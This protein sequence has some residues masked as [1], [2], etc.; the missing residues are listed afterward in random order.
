[1]KESSIVI[2]SYHSVRVPFPS[3]HSL[4]TVQTSLDLSRIGEVYFYANRGDDSADF[5]TLYGADLTDVSS[6]H[7]RITRLKHKGLAGIEK[8]I[9]VL[10]DIC[11]VGDRKKIVYVTQARPLHFFLFLKKM[12]VKIRILVEPHSE[13]EAWSKSDFETVDGIIFTSGTLQRRLTERYF[14]SPEIPQTVF[15]HRVRSSLSD[16]LSIRKSTDGNYCIGYIGGLEEWKGVNTIIEA[17]RYLPENVTAHFIGGETR[18][19]SYLLSRANELGI[20]K[21]LRFTGRVQ[22]EALIKESQDID[23]FILPL[24]QS[25]HGSLPMKLFDYMYLGKPIIAASQ[26][27]VKEILSDRSALFFPAGSDRDLAE[28]IKTLINNPSLGIDL[29]ENAYNALKSYTADKW[30][31]GME[32]FLRNI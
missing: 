20:E 5:R 27:S 25:E 26:E 23:A 10:K 1:M 32:Q 3:A 6:F 7:L 9:A 8:R 18:G 31:V 30:M 12:G 19:Q 4:Y 22:Q 2:L 28:R 17:L 24:L 16:K 21:R 13:T 11:R 29:S 14:I 15:Y